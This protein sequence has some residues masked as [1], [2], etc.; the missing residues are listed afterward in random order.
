MMKYIELTQ[1]KR[2][3]VD[4]EDYEWL[5]QWKW[6]YAK[7]SNGPDG[8]ACRGMRSIHLPNGYLNIMMHQAVHGTPEGYITDH[9]NGNK[10]DNRKS[11]LLTA[12]DAT[13]RINVSRRSD[14]T[15]SV[16]GVGWFKPTNRWRA[17]I[18]ING[19]LISLGYF[20][21]LEEAAKARKD[22][23]K[24]YYEPMVKNLNPTESNL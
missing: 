19:K 6:H 21:T 1:G 17:R 5:S 4:D 14:N 2:A 10:L 18:S 13:N 8:Y 22:A 20:K 16:T 9:K 3:I 24:F 7:S 15:S 23:E 11:N 12:T